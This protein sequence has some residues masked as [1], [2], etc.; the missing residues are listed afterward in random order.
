MELRTLTDAF[1][2]SGYE[3][4]VRA[5]I[6]KAAEKR[7]D[8]VSVDRMGN[9]ICRKP[10][11]DRAKPA[12][13]V[14]AHMDEI[15]FII[16][17]YTDDGLLRFRPIG[18]IDPR[19]V[20]SKWLSIGEEGLP[21]VIG[22]P[23]IHLQSAEERGQ[24]L[25]FNKLYIDIG[26]KDQKEAEGLAP[27][28]S[29]AV[30][31]TPYMEFGEG[32]VAA[33]ALDDRIGCFN[34]LKLL[35]E[36]YDSDLICVFVT[37]EEVGLRGSQTAAFAL[38]AEIAVVLEGTAA[39]DLG[40]VEERFHVCTPGEGVC[41]SFM[42]RASIADRELFR[43]MLELA[44]AQGIPAQVKRGITG[45]NDAASFQRSGRGMRTVV[46]SVPCRYIHSANN[47][48]KWSDIRAQADLARAF[49]KSL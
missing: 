8:D 11:R 2:P 9:L 24:V 5:L 37:Q 10:G 3:N 19:V 46:L 13:A 16:T 18:G 32:F 23:P 40:D 7:C 42:D 47:V 1:G 20:V 38:E 45:G 25:G 43:A 29:Y 27:L 12:V 34:L 15:G 4:P 31:D 44:K 17:G 35:E 22:A 39:N 6:R 26:A 28:G 21:G 30:F 33:K 48:A 14:A 49:L 41:V 36:E